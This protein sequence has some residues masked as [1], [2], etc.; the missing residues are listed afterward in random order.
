MAHLAKGASFRLI[1]SG[2]IGVKEI[3]RLIQKLEIDKEILA[4]SR[5]QR[6]RQLRPH[7][8]PDRARNPTIAFAVAVDGS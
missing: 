7:D 2:N 5:Q 8:G 3:E 4:E 1:V 6:G